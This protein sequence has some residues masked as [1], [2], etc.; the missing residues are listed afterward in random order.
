MDLVDAHGL[1]D[2]IAGESFPHPAGSMLGEHLAKRMIAGFGLRVP[3]GVLLSPD[4]ATCLDADGLKP[5]LAVKIVSPDIVH[6][7][8]QGFV[9]LG[10]RTREELVR[11][12][13]RMR[14][15][16]RDLDA[17]VEGFLVEEMAPPGIELVVGCFQDPVFG[18]MI[19]FGLGGI[20]VEV[21]KDV[22]FRICPIAR[23]D[24]EEMI[25]GLHCKPI[26]D[27]ARGGPRV[28]R[29]A[30][31]DLLL[32]VGGAD[33]IVM[34]NAARIEEMD[35]NPVIAGPAG[36]FVADARIRLKAAPFHA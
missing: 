8:D 36:I 35:L 14:E 21:F 27:G 1:A 17:A 29:G 12:I 30:L 31:L 24:A 3:R 15:A 26:L 5:P 16:A 9:A 25:D 23:I 18:P 6:K 34:S 22:A 33:G 11:A 19:M 10:V 4:P 2:G 20:H 28:D 7:S 32:R 13:S